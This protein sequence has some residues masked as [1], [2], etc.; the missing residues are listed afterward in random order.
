MRELFGSDSELSADWETRVSD[1]EN[2]SVT[3]NDSMDDELDE[4]DYGSLEDDDTPPPQLLPREQ[5]QIYLPPNPDFP[6]K[7]F[8]PY[9]IQRDYNNP[10]WIPLAVSDGSFLR[11]YGKRNYPGQLRTFSSVP[12]PHYTHILA[13]RQQLLVFEHLALIALSHHFNRYIVAHHQQAEQNPHY[14]DERPELLLVGPEG[15]GNPLLF[16]IERLRLQQ[17][18]GYFEIYNQAIDEIS[19]KSLCEMADEILSYRVYGTDRDIIIQQRLS[20]YYGPPYC[21]PRHPQPPLPA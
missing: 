11:P 13:R 15:D 17:L 21:I 18:L 9:T 12:L 19:I 20:G 1:D 5:V 16:A 10:R 14:V 4:S 6:R 8:T 7:K 3:A 2:E